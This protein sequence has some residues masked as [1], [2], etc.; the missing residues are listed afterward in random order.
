MNAEHSAVLDWYKS[1]AFELSRICTRKYIT[2]QSHRMQV[3]V[4]E[5]GE[6]ETEGMWKIRRFPTAYFRVL[7]SPDNHRHDRP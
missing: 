2:I 5:I 4:G 1:Y 3:T 6:R 7:G